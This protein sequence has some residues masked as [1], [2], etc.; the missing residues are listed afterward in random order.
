MSLSVFASERRGL[1]RTPFYAASLIPR[2][3]LSPFICLSLTPERDC[4]AAGAPCVGLGNSRLVHRR[5]KQRAAG[6]S[7]GGGAALASV[8]AAGDGDQPA[9]CAVVS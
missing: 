1:Y 5:G 8:L 6:L 2:Q 9:P 7:Q 3:P 4:V